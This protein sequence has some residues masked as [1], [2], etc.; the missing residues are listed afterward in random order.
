VGGLRA[1]ELVDTDLTTPYHTAGRDK[2]E[3]ETEAQGYKTRLALNRSGEV[4]LQK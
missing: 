2:N 3:A 1:T 4:C